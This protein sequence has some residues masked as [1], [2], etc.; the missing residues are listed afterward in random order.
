MNTPID[1]LLFALTLISYKI[2]DFIL[3]YPEEHT[4]MGPAG[5]VKLR[6]K[7]GVWTA[8]R[9]STYCKRRGSWVKHNWR[10][11]WRMIDVPEGYEQFHNRDNMTPDLGEAI[12]N[13]LEGQ[14]MMDEYKAGIMEG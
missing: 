9:V 6:H 10:H 4:V 8:V 13:M 11:G 7:G 3:G 5:E 2:L 14:R 12:Y 1:R